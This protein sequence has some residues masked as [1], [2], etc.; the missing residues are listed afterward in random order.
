[1]ARINID[2]KWFLD[3]RRE[4]LREKLKQST[5]YIDGLMVEVWRIAQHYYKTNRVGIPVSIFEKIQEAKEILDSDLAHRVNEF[6]YLKGSKECFNWL[7]QS[8]QSG[9]LGGLASAAL[10]TRNHEEIK[11]GSSRES[12][13]LPLPLSPSLKTKNNTCAVDTARDSKFQLEEIYKSYP[14]KLGKKRGIDRLRKEIKTDEDF[15]AL[16]AALNKY[17]THLAESK[18]EAKFIQ[19]FSTWTNSWRDWLDEDAGDINKPYVPKESMSER[20]ERMLREMMGD[21]NGPSNSTENKP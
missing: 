7:V 12:N 15:K 18:T 1:M 2:D 4:I 20:R 13:L 21:Q 14:R 19:H 3:P 17:K 5:R 10:R 6:V 9:K 11:Q 8:V 16:L